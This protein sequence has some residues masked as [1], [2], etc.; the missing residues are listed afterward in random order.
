MTGCGN[1]DFSGKMPLPVSQ[2]AVML[3]RYADVIDM[4]TKTAASDV[5]N[6]FAECARD[7]SLG[8]LMLWNGL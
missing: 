2:L 4:N 5:L 7:F 6:P 3:Y 1:G 8:S